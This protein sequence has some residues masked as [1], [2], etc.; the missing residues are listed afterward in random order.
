MSHLVFIYNLSVV[1]IAD[2]SC[3]CLPTKQ[4]CTVNIPSQK[5]LFNLIGCL[6]LINVFTGG[7]TR[8]VGTNALVK[9][10]VVVIAKCVHFEVGQASRNAK[11]RSILEIDSLG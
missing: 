6:I 4:A 10:E 7:Y 2:E 8:I 5:H 1:I 3:K 11:K 9:T